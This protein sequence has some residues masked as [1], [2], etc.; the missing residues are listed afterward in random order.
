MDRVGYGKP[1]D[2]TDLYAATLDA[3]L[4]FCILSYD[5]VAETYTTQGSNPPGQVLTA[6]LPFF[7]APLY[8][9]R[10][11]HVAWGLYWS[12]IAFNSPANLKESALAIYTDGRRNA[13]IRYL[14]A[15]PAPVP[16]R[17]ELGNATTSLSHASALQMIQFHDDEP[18]TSATLALDTI[19]YGLKWILVPGGETLRRETV[20]DTVAYAI[21]WTAQWSEDTRFTG[22]RSLSVPGG[23]MF[24]R[25]ESYR[26][27]RWMAMTYGFAATVI[28]TLPQLLEAHAKFQ[29]A[30][31]QV[32]TPDGQV[33]GSIGIFI[34]KD[35]YELGI[36]DKPDS[37]GVQAS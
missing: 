8:T 27:G 34:R 24:V 7:T 5:G 20:Y 25:L 17:L 18:S 10:N 1:L 15:T 3:L 36:V 31:F 35:I 22:F 26:V 19:G 30:L 32:L 9:A 14:Q 29:E 4:H 28:K 23:Q 13:V 11:C 16:V 12:V 33:C 37:G 21:L 2:S 6:V